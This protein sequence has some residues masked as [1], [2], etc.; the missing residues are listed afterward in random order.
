MDLAMSVISF[1]HI[2]VFTFDF[3]PS[4]SHSG[5]HLQKTSEAN[6]SV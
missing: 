6:A 4:T 3:G 1:S 5:S 2:A